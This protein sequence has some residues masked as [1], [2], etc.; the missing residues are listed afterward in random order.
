VKRKIRQ[1]LEA[2]KL[3]VLARLEAAL[4]RPT[5]AEDMGPVM[6]ARRIQ[7][8][9]ATKTQA[10][11]HGGIG[12]V[13]MLARKVGLPQRIDAELQLLKQHRPYHDSDHIL[14]IAY[15]PLCGG[16]VLDDIELRRNDES[17]LNAIGAEAIPDP[18]T[19]GDFCRRFD[20]DAVERLMGIINEV[21]VGVWKQQEPGFLKETARIDADG[22]IVPTSGECK[23]GMA[24][25]YNGEW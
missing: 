18:T 9:L 10:I 3:K 13:H 8:E 14:N 24:L 12:A 16:R 23:E 20:R 11:A 2:R 7:Y 21:R 4:D 17:F 1:N 6:S 19:A 15:N 22:T 25:S 5:D